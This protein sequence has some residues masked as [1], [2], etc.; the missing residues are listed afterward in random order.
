[1]S[2]VAR[3]VPDDVR[4]AAAIHVPN[5]GNA[6]RRANGNDPALLVDDVCPAGDSVALHEPDLSLAGSVVVPDDVRLA[7]TVHIPNTG[8]TPRR[9]DKDGS[10]PLV[11]HICSAGD[12]V[13][14]HEPD[15]VSPA[16]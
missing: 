16:A 7:V 15:R 10:T 3:V 8:D 14:L 13:G 12:L 11:D 5:A 1:M 2:P 4:V 6:P 9:S